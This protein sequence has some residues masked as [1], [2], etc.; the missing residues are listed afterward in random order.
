[1]GTGYYQDHSMCY[2]CSDPCGRIWDG[3]N[4]SRNVELAGEKFGSLHD[5]MHSSHLLY[6]EWCFILKQGNLDKTAI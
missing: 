2:G 1:M 6:D 5:K 4:E 3:D